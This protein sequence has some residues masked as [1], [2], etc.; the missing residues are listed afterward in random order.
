MSRLHYLPLFFGD[1]LASTAEWAG[2][3]RSLYLT[4]LGY[5]WSLGS[6]PTDPEKVRRLVQWERETFDRCWPTVAAKFI[7]ADGRLVN[8]RLE[9]HREKAQAVASK[10]A[11]SGAMGAAARWQKEGTEASETDSNGIA[12]AMP[13]PLQKDGDCQNFAMPSNP[14]QSKEEEDKNPPTPRKRGEVS[15]D[16]PI[17]EGPDPVVVVFD[18]WRKVHGHPRAGLDKKRRAVIRRALATYSVDDLRACIDGY[19]HSP[20]HMGQNDRGTVFDAIELFLRDAAH[21]DAGIKH[22]KPKEQPWM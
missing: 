9:T 8:T 19:K 15:D 12:N 13:L 18:H 16:P 3:E 4:L 14:I 7:E 1:F 10:R 6:L 21:I 17:S 2:E 22:G 5:Q 11:K 20:H